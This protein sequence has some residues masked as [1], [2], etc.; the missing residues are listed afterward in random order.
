MSALPVFPEASGIDY[1]M[2]QA[3]YLALD[4]IGSSDIKRLLRSPAHYQAG[5]ARSAEPTDAMVIGTA[6]HLAVLEPERFALEVVQRP[7]FDRRTTTGKAAFAAWTAE[8]AGRLALDAEDFD[9]VRR[10]ADSVLAHPAARALL[11]EGAPEVSL[12]WDDPA[13]ATPCRARFDWLRPDL[14]AIDLKSTRDA[15]PAGFPREIAQHGYHLQAA[16]YDMGAQAVLG[17]PLPYW[18][19]IAIE[20]EAPYAVGVYSLDRESIDAASVRVADALARW[21][22]ATDSGRWPAYSDLIDPI[23]LPKW[24]L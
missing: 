10:S 4:A 17:Q 23:T 16:H 18:I 15:S 1:A 13:T 2:P 8:H 11:S 22:A 24:A 14:G 6:I 20:K 21:R 7:T 5:R 19:F 9:T 12:R 3:D